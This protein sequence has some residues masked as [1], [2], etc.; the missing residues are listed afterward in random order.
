MTG[1][2][3]SHLLHFEAYCWLLL[4]LAAAVAVAAASSAEHVWHDIPENVNGYP[5][6]LALRSGVLVKV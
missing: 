1:N 5:R 2:S 3:I 4:L 6:L